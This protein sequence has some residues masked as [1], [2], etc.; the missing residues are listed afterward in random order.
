MLRTIAS[1]GALA[2]T[3]IGLPALAGTAEAATHYTHSSTLKQDCAIHH[4][5]P[6]SGVPDRT[7]TK[8]R[9]SA[10]GSA[11][12]VGVRYTYKGYAMVL[13]YAQRTDP[14]WGFIAQSCLT[15]PH[16]YSGGDH[17]SVLG[18]LRAIGGG[19]A[20]KTVP[21][22][23]PHSGRTQSGTIHLGSNGSMRSGARSF[24]IGNAA[25]GDTFRITT[26]HCGRH[27]KESWILGYAPSSGRWGYIEAMHLPACL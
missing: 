10:G 26:A 22:S 9:T 19:G 7:W 25:K 16:A 1:A 13:D 18:D 23:A 17:G 24:V 14:S 8:A 11:T 2:G 21:I 15:D 27:S 20:V 4:N 6:K 3:L 12:H 5:F